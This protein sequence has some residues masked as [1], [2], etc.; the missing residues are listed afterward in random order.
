M[1][2]GR[3]W[4]GRKMAA[5]EVEEV[6]M[7]VLLVVLVKRERGRGERKEVRREKGRG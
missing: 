7:L 3:D 5:E 6:V 4:R 2:M 1:V